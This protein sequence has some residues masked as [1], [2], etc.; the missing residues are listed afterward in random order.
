M[1]SSD[2]TFEKVTP[3]D[4]DG[5]VGLAAAAWYSPDGLGDSSAAA[6]DG[7]GLPADERNEVARLLATDEVSAYLA[8]STWGMKALVDGRIAG[9][10][11]T[12]G[13]H[14]D[15]EASA[16]WKRVGRQ[17]REAAERLLARAR[18]REEHAAE[19]SEPVYLDE[20]RATNEMRAAAGLDGQPRVL[21]LVIGEA[22]R[23]HGIGRRLLALARDHFSRHGASRYWLVTDTDCDWPFYEHLELERLAERG[24]TVE[25]A[26]ERYFVYG[27]RA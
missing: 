4:L 18:E 19:P 15:P 24:S 23:G 5:I 11:L 13:T 9:V 14:D 1:S 27:G 12:H 22:A 16:R 25:G 2:V 10:I 17:A 3:A 20:V 21:L 26:P 6:A 7:A 8:D